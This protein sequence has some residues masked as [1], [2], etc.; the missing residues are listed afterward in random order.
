MRV[1]HDAKVDY[2]CIDFCDA[3][4]AKSVYQDGIIVRYDHQDSVIGVDITDSMKLFGQSHYLNFSEVCDLLRVSESTLRR[5]I[6]AGKINFFKEGNRYRFRR[7]EILA[8][9]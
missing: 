1:H 2:L 3:V 6:R 7:S 8:M 9:L 5:R 4:E